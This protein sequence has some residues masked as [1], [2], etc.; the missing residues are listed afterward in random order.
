M[1]PVTDSTPLLVDVVPELDLLDLSDLLALVEL[2]LFF[3]VVFFFVAPDAASAR[4]QQTSRQQTAQRT[5][6]DLNGDEF[7]DES[8]YRDGCRKPPTYSSGEGN[9]SFSPAG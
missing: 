8:P 4:Q 6:F 5:N 3:F 2:E 9:A 1:A 7:I